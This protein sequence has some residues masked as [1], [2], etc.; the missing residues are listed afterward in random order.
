MMEQCKLVIT[1][2]ALVPENES[3]G[4]KVRIALAEYLEKL[5]SRVYT[6]DF[7]W[8]SELGREAHEHLEASNGVSITTNAE[9][10]RV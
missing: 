8:I 7:G 1:L 2:S 10:L 6:K 3:W 5:N 9:Y 4:N